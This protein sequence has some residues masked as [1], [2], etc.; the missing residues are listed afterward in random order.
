M[1]IR[2]YPIVT[3]VSRFHLVVRGDEAVLIDAG[4]FPRWGPVAQ[5][6][7][8]AGIRPE[9]IRAV[10]LTHGHLDHIGLIHQ[11]R[12]HTPARVWIHRGDLAHLRQRHPYRGLT[13]VCG[14]LEWTG[15][16]L[17]GLRGF[18]ADEFFEP[19]DQLPFLGG[20]EVMHL[21]GHT[22]GHCGFWSAEER[23]LFSGDLFANYP[24]SPHQPPRFL[25]GNQLLLRESLQRAAALQP[26][27][28]V[29]NHYWFADY[30]K[31]ALALQHLARGTSLRQG[32]DQ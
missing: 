31:H 12:E 3:I 25:N 28:V 1:A 26:E 22:R 30:E 10:L 2:I 9:Q 5:A 32:A 23:L 17:L 8:R 20:L 19:H 16:Q 21:P 15:R 27:R 13:R 7:K 29:P 11:V 24:P 18:E 6:C 14:A 4:F